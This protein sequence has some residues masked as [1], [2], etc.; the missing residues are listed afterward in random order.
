[1]D[2]ARRWRPRTQGRRRG[3]LAA[4]RRQGRRRLQGRSHHR[5]RRDRDPFG[6]AHPSHAA[7]NQSG[8]R[9]CAA[10][11]SRL[12]PPASSAGKSA[13]TGQ[14]GGTAVTTAIEDRAGTP[15]VPK[16]PRIARARAI[17]A[18]SVSAPSV[19]ASVA[20]PGLRPRGRPHGRRV[21]DASARP[22]PRCPRSPSDRSRSG[23]SRAAPI[24]S[25]CSPRCPMST[26][27][28]PTSSSAVACRACAKRCRS[29]TTP[30]K[31]KAGQPSRPPASSR[32]PM[33]CSPR[34]G[35]PSGWIEPKP[36]SRWSTSSTFATCVRW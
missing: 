19:T 29:R 7:R 24:A 4:R 13:T 35:W 14:A 16:A 25:S 20:H 32:W 23:S 33:I 3:D 2:L 15:S 21:S 12:S 6:G 28:S 9:S 17:G 22:S 26:G 30:S 34:C 27:P 5:P 36:R 1:M 10:E 8:S 18:V 31:P 11:T